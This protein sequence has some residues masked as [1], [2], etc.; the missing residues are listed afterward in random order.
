[1]QLT[2]LYLYKCAL[3]HDPQYTCTSGLQLTTFANVIPWPH[4]Y[5]QAEVWHHFTV[6]FPE[7]T[8]AEMYSSFGFSR[9]KTTAKNDAFDG[10]FCQHHKTRFVNWNATVWVAHACIVCN[11]NSIID[12]SYS[13]DIGL[14]QKCQGEFLLIA[15]EQWQLANSLLQR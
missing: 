4:I 3:S 2:L 6:H 13:L 7:H 11:C 15:T 14:R 8:F 9:C 5:R 12:S 10:A 1:M